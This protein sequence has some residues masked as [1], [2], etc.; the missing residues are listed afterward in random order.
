MKFC[1]INIPTNIFREEFEI[2]I[3]IFIYFPEVTPGPGQYQI[4]W[5]C[6]GSDSIKYTIYSTPR[7][8][9]KCRKHDGRRICIECTCVDITTKQYSK[10]DFE[11][12]TPPNYC[13][14]N[15]TFRR[16]K[17]NGVEF[18]RALCDLVLFRRQN[19][20]DTFFYDL[21]S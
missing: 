6:V 8:Q 1:S 16:S 10:N 9:D 15:I 12:V 5:G 7:F 13:I 3:L 20:V 11:L 18:R 4:E 21:E 19:G 14:K 2:P 17:A